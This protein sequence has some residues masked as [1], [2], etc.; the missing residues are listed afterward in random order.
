MNNRILLFDFVRPFLALVALC[1]AQGIPAKAQADFT[2]ERL[3][4]L[5]LEYVGKDL[6]GGKASVYLDL[7]YFNLFASH[8]K[9]WNGGDGVYSTTLPDGN[10]FW[11]FGD[12]FFGLISEFRNRR[13]PANLP[14]NAA[15]I[16]TGEQSHRDFIVLN[17][18]CSTDP[19]DREH[20][21]KGKTWL[22]HPNAKALTQKEIDAGS[23]DSDRFYWPGDATVI[24]REGKPI[25]QV[26]WGSIFG[27]MNRDETALSEYSLEGTPGDGEYMKLIRLIPNVVEYCG[28]YGSGIIEAPDG[29]TYLYGTTGTGGLGS[30]PI[31][32]R[33]ATHDLTSQWE[34]WIADADGNFAWQTEIPSEAEIMRSDISHG[35]WVTEPSMMA[36]GDY[37]YMVSQDGLNGNIYIYQAKDPWGPF[38]NR[39]CLYNVP[40]EHAATYNTFVHPQLSR[41]GEL[42]ISYN[43][44]AVT[45][46]TYH[47]NSKGEIVEDNSDGFWRNFNAWESADL[48]QPHFIRVF[49]WQELFGQPDLG[50]VTDAGIIEYEK[51]K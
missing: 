42:V 28:G 43:M 29:H 11:S 39:K 44:N 45:L 34:Y 23:T 17:E 35:E 6:S 24:W 12:S 22:R 41:T 49:G 13:R 1:L 19:N 7:T 26:L 5:E 10:T 15:M 51:M 47:K 16:Q 33:A 38:T 9:G 36:Y 48:Y 2:D 46:V 8:Q 32:A 31:V 27:N 20:Y 4:R 25:L 21:Y 18:L 3:D 14:R 40:D 37:Y 30:V 50:P